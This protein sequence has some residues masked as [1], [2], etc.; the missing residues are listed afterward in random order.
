[1]RYTGTVY[2][3]GGKR[4]LFH[5]TTTAGGDEPAGSCGKGQDALEKRCIRLQIQGKGADVPATIYFDGDWAD[6]FAYG[7]ID[8]TSVKFDKEM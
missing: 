6:L 1:M 3:K 7:M 4:A 5:A 2:G 8:V